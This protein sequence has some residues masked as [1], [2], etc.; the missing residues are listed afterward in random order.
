MTP[1]EADT[2][3]ARD[4][5]SGRITTTSFPMATAEQPRDPLDPASRAQEALARRRRRHLCLRLSV[6]FALSGA[7]IGLPVLTARLLGEGA[8]VGAM[9]GA[10]LLVGIAVA[11]LPYSWSAEERAYRELEAI[12]RQLRMDADAVV[13][14]ERYVVWAESTGGVVELSLIR[15]AP[16]PGGAP[17]PYERTTVSTLDPDDMMAAADAMERLRAQAM[18]RERAAQERHEK[19]ALET[20]RLAHERLLTSIDEVAAADMEAREVELRREVAQREAR[21]REAQASALARALR[22]P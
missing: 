10:L 17:N 2:V 9:V 15:R 20:D 8:T 13:P 16:G 21:D 5:R 4:V 11:V 1:P 19:D 18:E 6:A 12:W 7:A 22:R 14:W 3:T